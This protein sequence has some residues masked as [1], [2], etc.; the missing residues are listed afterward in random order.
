MSEQIR[1]WGI[2]TDISTALF[3]AE[4]R[5]LQKRIDVIDQENRKLNQSIHYGFMHGGKNYNPS[6]APTINQQRNYPVLHESLHDEMA[7][8]L[9][10]VKRTSY[11]KSRM[12]Q[13]LVKV[14]AVC[15]T[16]QQ[17]RDSIP[18]FLVDMVPEL[19]GYDR[20]HPE[21]IY[22]SHNEQLLR[23]YRDFRERAEFFYATNMLY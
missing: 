2:A 20:H 6:D 22:I 3:K 12:Y 23:Y 4:K 11:E 9:E 21:E 5:R 10:D 15:E 13:V 7:H 1:R 18:D 14:F 8:Y 16:H 19:K 17:L